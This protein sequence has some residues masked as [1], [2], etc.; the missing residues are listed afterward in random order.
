M[1]Y[2]IRTIITAVIAVLPVFFAEAQNFTRENAIPFIKNFSPED[3]HAHEQNFDITQDQ[4][5]FMYFANFAGILRYDGENWNL[6]SMKSGMRV[7]ALD[8]D[9]DGKVYAGG[10]YDFGYTE[11]DRFGIPYFVSLAPAGTQH[12]DPPT[13]THINSVGNSTF[14]LSE[15]VLYE[16]SDDKLKKI[17]LPGKAQSAFE[18][19]DKYYIFFSIDNKDSLQ[20][21]FRY[22][23]GE[24]IALSQDFEN[25]LIDVQFMFSLPENDTI[26][27]GTSKQGFYAL[28]K[29]LIKELN[30]EVKEFTT[31]RSLTCGS[32]AGVSDFVIGTLT[33]GLIIT[34]FEGNVLQE[35]NSKSKLRNDVINKVYKDKNGHIWVAT[36]DGISM[37]DISKPVRYID[38]KTGLPEG[39]INRIIDFNNTVFIASNQGLYYLDGHSVKKNVQMQHACHD[40]INRNGYIVAAT[41]KGIYLADRNSAKSTDIKEYSFTVYVSK[42][43]P[44]KLYIGQTDRVIT[45]KLSEF[46]QLS[47]PEKIGGMHGN[48]IRLAE[49]PKQNLLFAENSV[50]KIFVHELSSGQ[51]FEIHSDSSVVAFKI[52]ELHDEVFFSSEKGLFKYHAEKRSLEPT[53][54]S[55]KTDRLNWISQILKLP[56][57]NILFTDGANKNLAIYNPVSGKNMQT[58]FLP[59]K[60]FSVTSLFYDAAF[61]KILIGGNKTLLVYDYEIKQRPELSFKPLFTKITDI[62][63][64][65]ILELQFDNSASVKWPFSANSLEFQFSSPHY[66]IIGEI[67]Y[68]SFLQGFDKDTSKWTSQ[69]MRQYTN[70]PDKKYILTIEARNEYGTYLGQ[71]YLTFEIRTPLYR[72]WWAVIIY[73]ALAGAAVKL[74]FDY[75]LKTAEKEKNAL[76]Q[77][78]KERTEEIEKSKEEI[79]AQRDTAYKQRK[80]IID[81]INY[82]QRIQRAVLPSEDKIDELLGDYF[83]FFK[84]YEIVSGDFFWMKKIKNFIAVAAADCTGHGVPGAFMS[85]L[86]SS[87]LNELVTGRSMDSTA[88]ILNRLRYKVKKSLHQEGKFDDQKDGMDISFYLVD[89]ETLELQFSG[90]YNPLYIIRHKDNFTDEDMKT[91]ESNPSVKL[92]KNTPEK[93]DVFIKNQAFDH[94]I[95]E[96]KANRQPIGIYIKETD[97]DSIHF[98][99]KAGDA[100]YNFSDGYVDQ[101]GGET[102][103]K[104]KTKR[105]KELLLS[106]QNKPMHE[107]KHILDQTFYRWKGNLGQTDDIIVIGYKV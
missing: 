1:N 102:G 8:T 92:T 100:L 29:N 70:L 81:S 61:N 99:L 54:I 22:E 7:L 86:G 40:I 52:I 25:K 18:V 84:P 73:L 34:D 106:I 75:R 9:N 65:S 93:A 2:R 69:S 17:P 79:E 15:D 23:N 38:D 31:G 85:M 96:L 32:P 107:Q 50:G 47:H 16:Y 88:E 36:D 42:I 64:D 12:Q 94:Y 63:N 21:L 28:N 89:T 6:I 66:P 27:I 76:E 74:F 45:T 41:T 80:E 97:F 35:I 4:D 83:V 62:N 19:R 68:R 30:P 77:I 53:V 20:G 11:T 24:F 39:R 59:H 14:F 37:T 44:D 33:S 51:S 98:Q 87:F 46:P 10:L 56:D 26:Y 90:A 82:A 43:N 71:T 103:S 101:F 104:F 3:Y 58:D 5:G 91:I 57:G 78:V 105:F 60:N 48:I 67:E 13:I 55:E 49:D 95:I 72:R